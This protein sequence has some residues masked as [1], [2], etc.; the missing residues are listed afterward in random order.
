MIITARGASKADGSPKD[1]DRELVVAFFEV[2]ESTSQF[3]V[4]NARAY[5]KA[6][7]PV[8]LD[9]LFGLYNFGRFDRNFRESINGMLYGNTPGLT[10]NVGERVRWYLMA[11]TN[12][13]MHAPHWHGN[14]VVIHEMRTD[15]TSLTPMEMVT[16]DMV[17]DDPGTW[18]FHCHTAPHLAMGME[19]LYHVAR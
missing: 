4:H 15:V 13:E 10:M 12:F 6:K 7:D 9:T 1:V 3:A 14:T 18:L 2:D 11:N 17:P 19:A 5:T 8:K 16:A